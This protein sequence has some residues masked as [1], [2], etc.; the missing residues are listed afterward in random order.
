MQQIETKPTLQ[1]LHDFIQ[2]C[3]VNPTADRYSLFSSVFNLSKETIEMLEFYGMAK[4]TTP[5]EQLEKHLQTIHQLDF[6][7]YIHDTLQKLIST[8]C[9]NQT[10][11][12]ELYLLD[13]NDTFGR[14]KLGGVSAIAEYDG[15][16]TFIAYPE[17]KVRQV[18]ESV[19]FHEFH[20]VWRIGLLNIK[21]ETETLLDR[22][23]LEGLAEYFV[24]THLG[25]D[26][27]GPYNKVL[28]EEQ[29]ELLWKSHYRDHL[30][31]KGEATN[32]YMFGGEKGLPMWAGYS[33][34]Y[35]LVQWYCDS[36][37]DLTIEDL[38]ALPPEAFIK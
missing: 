34:G 11:Q 28:S 23:V 19:V 9:P 13:E 25:L 17:K 12:F 35:H 29:A 6:P 24:G 36:H 14:E 31:L 30:L 21:E 22:L 20:H 37:P 3:R 15:T 32:P 33:M 7:T 2:L 8:Y 1:L 4:V 5:I 10:A 27:Q 18:L 26:R 16:I 38:T